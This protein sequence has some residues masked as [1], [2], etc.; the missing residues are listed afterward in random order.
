M[1][2][3]CVCLVGKFCAMKNLYIVVESSISLGFLDVQACSFFTNRL[4]VSKKRPHLNFSFN[5]KLLS[6]QIRKLLTSCSA[7][8]VWRDSDH[9]AGE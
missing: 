3:K 2:K 7:N 9:T 6:I 1:V 8:I 5:K 4:L